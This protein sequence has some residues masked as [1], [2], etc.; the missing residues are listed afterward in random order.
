MDSGKR[1]QPVVGSTAYY[2]RP[3]L[4]NS[5][6]NPH[7]IAK[8]EQ[9]IIMKHFK[10][11]IKCAKSIVNT[12]KPIILSKKQ[13]RKQKRALIKAKNATVKKKHFISPTLSSSLKGEMGKQRRANINK[14]TIKHNN[15][16]TSSSPIKTKAYVSPTSPIHNSY[17]IKRGNNVPK[18]GQNNHKI[19]ANS[20]PI[21]Q[22]LLYPLSTKIA[23]K[24]QKQ[25][26]KHNKKLQEKHLKSIG[27][28]KHGNKIKQISPIKPKWDD[29]VYSLPEPKHEVPINRHPNKK[30]TKL[31]THQRKPHNQNQTF[32]KDQTKQQWQVIAGEE[33]IPGL[34]KIAGNIKPRW[35][36]QH[37]GYK[38]LRDLFGKLEINQDKSNNDCSF[39]Y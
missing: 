36:R 28:P 18:F 25:L 38:L 24:R 12:N 14:I 16:T 6:K 21:V 37:K 9:K 1:M 13:R 22:Q 27:Y 30:N 35:K 33:D 26:L 8:F 32:N 15:N 10:D 3:D 29:N 5:I 11:S 2:Q 19:L 31:Y 7:P 34:I 17:Q 20:S 4:A 39:Q 23:N